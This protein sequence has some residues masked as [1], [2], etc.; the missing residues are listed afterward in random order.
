MFILDGLFSFNCFYYDVINIVVTLIIITRNIFGFWNVSIKVSVIVIGR[1]FWVRCGSTKFNT[2]LEKWK[3]FWK[4]SFWKIYPSWLGSRFSFSIS[5]LLSK[6][7][8]VEMPSILKDL[9]FRR[10]LGTLEFFLKNYKKK[11]LPSIAI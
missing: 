5:S 6:S 9:S 11:V 10:F 4:K 3:Y 8:L 1:I 2:K 7:T